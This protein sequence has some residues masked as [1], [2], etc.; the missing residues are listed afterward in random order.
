MKLY[1]CNATKQEFLFTYSLPE[2]LRPFSH[3]IRAGS[4]VEITGNQDAIDA[5]INQHSLYG[6]VEANKV[7]KGFGGLCYRIDKPVSLEAIQQ[8]LSQ[9]EQDMVDKA[10]ESRKLTAAAADQ[11][12]TQRAQEMGITQKS[13][14]EI[15]VVEENR[16]PAD[17]GAK[18][19]ETIEIVKDGG[20]APRKS[21]S[22]K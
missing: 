18:F 14:L 19:N 16:G 3:N 4:Q 8:G 10:L 6:L 22:K 2:N 1:I 15:E 17:G 12:L 11:I 7:K 13:P 5:I 21:R 20:P 9:T